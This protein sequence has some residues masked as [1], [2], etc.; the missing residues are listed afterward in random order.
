[1]FNDLKALKRINGLKPQ[2]LVDSIV[3]EGVISLLQFG[4]EVMGFILAKVSV[5]LRV[6]RYLVVARDSRFKS[7]REGKNKC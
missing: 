3:L 7:E 4:P 2:S 6:R 1:M 5:N